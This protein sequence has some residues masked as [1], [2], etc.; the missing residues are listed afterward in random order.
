VAWA[1][2]VTVCIVWGTTYLAIRIALE[3]F[4]PFLLTAFR[5]TVAGILLLAFCWWRGERPPRSLSG[6]T[7]IA[8]I[9]FLMV[10]IGN[11]AVVWAE[12][13]IP[14]GFAALMVAVSPFWMVLMEMM[15]GNQQRLRGRQAAGLLIGF[16]GVILLVLPH[17]HGASFNLDF[18]LGV[19]AIQA[20]S[21]GWNLG[22]V[23][24]KY[25]AG[26][27]PPLMSAGLQMLFGGVMVG[28]LGLLV[29]EGPHFHSSP[30]S[31]AALLYLT[32]MGS[33]V[34]YTAYVYALAHL[35][36]STMSLYAY[37]NPVI[38]VFAGW[39]IAGEEMG[40]RT[41]VAAAVILA[42]VAMVQRKSEE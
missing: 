23:R 37:V 28:I 32:V 40:W 7:H 10:V 24:S 38:A 25:H 29:G 33:F 27:T 31:L 39:L 4:P 15:R 26:G 14:S 22:S 17:L 21:I 3:T 5:F 12:K 6:L 30:R 34:A 18:V 42:G 13:F 41:I 9:G 19:L 1:A 35:P 11:F 36:T 20:G 8:A 16:S 2:F